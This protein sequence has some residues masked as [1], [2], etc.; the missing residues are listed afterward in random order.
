MVY[1]IIIK[2]L[3]YDFKLCYIGIIVY[4]KYILTSILYICVVC[5]EDPLYVP[6]DT[7][8]PG[9]NDPLDVLEIGA[10]QIRT[11]EIVAVKILG[12]LALIDDGETDW[13]VIVIAISDAMAH[14]IND[15][16]D[17]E[18]HLPGVIKAIRE[19]FRDYKSF[20]GKINTYALRAQAMPRHYAVKVIE[21]CHKH[22]KQLHLVDKMDIVTKQHQ[23]NN[24]NQESKDNNNIIN[25]NDNNTL[26]SDLGIDNEIR[27]SQSLSP[28]NIILS[29][30]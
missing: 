16:D 8:C 18:T 4:V 24:S 2:I 25:N 15:I 29:P 6:S 11:G 23:S 27:P 9:D 10:K 13:K 19:Y 5:R 22:W 12:V 1:I 21:D 28:H 7:Q 30:K 20:S 14:L 17:V 26:P 3:N